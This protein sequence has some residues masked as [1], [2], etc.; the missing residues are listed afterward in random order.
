MPVIRIVGRW[1]LAVGAAGT[2]AGCAL[3]GPPTATDIQ[4]DA[5][6]HTAVP[7]DWKGKGGG[8]GLPV[9]DAW[10]TSFNDPVLSALVDEALAYNTDLQIAAAR[11]EQAAGYVKV[12]GASLYPAVG[13]LAHGGDKSG[14]GG[15]LQGIFLNA[16]LELDVWGRVR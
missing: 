10:L 16:S 9:S 15:G 1:M 5:L 14:G 12:A 2:I 7:V 13:V 3:K 4:R 8:A 6:A 11:V